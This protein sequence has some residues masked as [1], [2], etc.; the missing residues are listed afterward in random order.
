MSGR[1]LFLTVGDART[2]STRYRVL[3]H[4]GALESAGFDPR[5]RYPRSLRRSGPL[6]YAWRTMDLMQD[7]SGSG[8]PEELLFVQRK[9]Y[10]PAFASRLSRPGRPLVFDM[11]DALDI[12][13]PG[14]D[15][16][17]RSVDRYRRNFEATTNAADLVLVGSRGLASRVPHDRVELL[18]TAIDTERFAPQRVGPPEGPTLGWVGHSGN[19]TYLESLAEPLRELARRHEGLRLVVV[20][21]REPNLPGIE[22]EFRRWSLDREVECFSGIGVGLMPLSDT[23][24]ARG[25]CA[26]KAIQYMALGIPAVASPVGANRELIRSGENGF[27][28]AQAAEWVHAVD[29]LLTSPRLSRRLGDAGRR[30][31]VESYSAEVVSRRLVELLRAVSA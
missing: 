4:L 23:P 19:L 27:L 26:F 24:W 28:A 29:A 30:T 20:A 25:K 7:V 15:L 3:A 31:V 21:D 8:D 2:A 6:R 11:D 13:P 12:P 9:M 1:I 14:R 18:P 17:P 10:P 16:G 5:V 22:V